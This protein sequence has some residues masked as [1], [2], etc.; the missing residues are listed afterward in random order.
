MFLGERHQ[1]VMRVSSLTRVHLASGKTAQQMAQ[2]SIN[3][4]GGLSGGE[5]FYLV[6]HKQYGIKKLL[7]ERVR[8]GGFSAN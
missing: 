5:N 8:H 2:Q 6:S 7:F 1:N 4:P 3:P